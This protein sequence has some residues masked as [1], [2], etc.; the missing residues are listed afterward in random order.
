M[1]NAVDLERGMT[2]RISEKQGDRACL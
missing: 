2:A 1:A